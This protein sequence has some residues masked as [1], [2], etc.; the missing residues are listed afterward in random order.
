M[1]NIVITVC[2]S[3]DRTTTQ[4]TASDRKEVSMITFIFQCSHVCD[5]GLAFLVVCVLCI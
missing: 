4:S 1:D 3:V 2:T 5:M